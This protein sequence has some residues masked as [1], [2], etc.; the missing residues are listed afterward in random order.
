MA[1]SIQLYE[2]ESREFC[3]NHQDFQ[4]QLGNIM[5]QTD[6]NFTA[7]QWEQVETKENVAAL[8]NTMGGRV[9]SLRTETSRPLD[10]LDARLANVEVHGLTTKP[11]LV[12]AWV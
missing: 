10:T 9:D 6:T 1:R 11:Y 7:L 8:N 12:R 4:A 3:D 5:V 2:V